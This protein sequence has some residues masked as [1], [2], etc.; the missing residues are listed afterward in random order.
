MWPARS[1][2]RGQ[3]GLAGLRVA[4]SRGFH[5]V[6]RLLFLF[7]RFYTMI[8][9][10]GVRHRP[11]SVKLH[12]PFHGQGLFSNLERLMRDCG[13]RLKI[14]LFYFGGWMAGPW[15]AKAREPVPPTRP[16]RPPAVAMSRPESGADSLWAR[17]YIPFDT[18]EGLEAGG[19]RHHQERGQP[20]GPPWGP[21]WRP[22]KKAGAARRTFMPLLPACPSIRRGATIASPKN[23]LLRPEREDEP[24]PVTQVILVI[25]IVDARNL[26]SSNVRPRLT[27]GCYR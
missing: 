1:G 21:V 2:F 24:H 13:R 25:R 9:I 3:A 5:L 20:P 15:L 7:R 14:F 12:S 8:A 26:L 10:V 17:T 4:G 16:G 11:F 18:R 19:G 22:K 27:P 6:L 23:E